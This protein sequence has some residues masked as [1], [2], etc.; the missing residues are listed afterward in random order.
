AV[1]P[2]NAA[3]G[4]Y[5]DKTGDA[6]FAAVLPAAKNKAAE[7]Y[8]ALK[9]RKASPGEIGNAAAALWMQGRVQIGLSLMAKACKDAPDNID[10]ASNY[11]AML[12]MMGKP[13]LAIPVLNNLNTRF[14]KNSTILNNLG[15]AWF[16]LGDI[17]K[18][19]KY[20]D[21]T[22]LLA[23]GHAQA[24]ETLCLIAESKGD[25]T[26][27]LNYAKTAF[28]QGATAARKDMLKKLG[29]TPGAGDYSG[30][31]P[32]NKSDDLLNLG[33]FAPMEFPRSYAAMKVY[34]E[35]RKKFLADI[36]VQIK[37]LKKISDESNKQTVKRLEDQ[38][39]QVMD[40]MNKVKSNPGSMSQASAMQMAGVPMFSEKMNA[41][42]KLVLE[43]LQRKKNEVL[44]KIADF[45]KGDWA[46]YKREYDAAMKKVNEKWKGVGEGGTENNASLCEESV[47]AIDTYLNAVNSKLEDLYHEYL[48][49]QKQY[50][51]EMSY[52]SLYTTYPELLPAINAGLKQQWL[53]DLS[54]K[55]EV[56]QVS[57]GCTVP[58]KIK[59][60][61]LSQFKDPNCNIHSE[62][63]QTLGIANLGF[64]MTLD[65]SGLTTEFNALAVGIKLT[66]D[67]DHAG[68][69][70]SY[71]NCTVSIGPKASVGGKLGPLEASVNVGGGVDVEIDRTGI[72]DV[73][74]K[75]G[76]EVE[77]GLHNTGI[78]D[79][80]LLG[81]AASGTA[82]VEGRVSIITGAASVQGT[83]MFN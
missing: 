73:V 61:R 72:T 12:T 54:F 74:V 56:L 16:A 13:E 30:F 3:M 7:V 64:K 71:K 17:D 46:G 26:A 11:A 2:A 22:L 58:G 76:A 23:A 49:A 60:G 55:P 65:C 21:S 67:L 10:N 68:F 29:Y 41:K 78:K 83:G 36:D 69:G 18:S 66:Q 9:E 5:L 77:A 57:Y 82:G 33:S 70:D 63:G 80:G 34:E 24:N 8:S 19:K 15:Q 4:A 40:A 48:S 20:L 25:K 62:F 44:Q 79:P 53:N 43:N 32:D 6:A 47:K 75:A 14:K 52:L 27:A 45:R 50:L 31:P 81:T 28:K 39:K 35:Q 37:P 1:T 42:E 38:G 51:N 59:E